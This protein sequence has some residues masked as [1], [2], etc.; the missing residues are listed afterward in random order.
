M[1]E[2]TT[3][4]EALIANA[5]LL[6]ARISDRL[7]ENPYGAV[8]DD[9]RHAARDIVLCLDALDATHRAER[10]QPA[11]SVESLA[12]WCREVSESLGLC[13]PTLHDSAGA[14]VESLPPGGPRGRSAEVGREEAATLII[15]VRA[16]AER[17]ARECGSFDDVL[18]L[19]RGNIEADDVQ[20]AALDSILSHFF[21]GESLVRQLDRCGTA[22]RPRGRGLAQRIAEA[23][24][25]LAELHEAGVDRRP[26][27]EAEID[28]DAE[29]AAREVALTESWARTADG[30]AHFSTDPST[31]TALGAL[32]NMIRN[33]IE[34]P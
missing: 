21:H 28:A 2:P 23:L 22:A 18:E 32:A 14:W 11:A 9:V 12:A 20:N 6:A 17:N 26:D 4:T 31:R 13:P 3:S 10:A 29:A 33:R 19:L 34:A 25:R 7:R 1:P 8:T 5:R 27:D 24:E 16:A 30:V 15:A